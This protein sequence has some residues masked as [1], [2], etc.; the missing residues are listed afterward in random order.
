MFNHKHIHFTPDRSADNLRSCLKKIIQ[1]PA[2]VFYGINCCVASTLSPVHLA[3]WGLQKI[4]KTNFKQSQ[5]H[6]TKA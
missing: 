5:K 3:S 4:F 1:I 2:A 6:K